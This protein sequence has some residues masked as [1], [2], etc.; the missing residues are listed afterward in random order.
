MI[1]FES[2]LYNVLRK[3][4][5]YTS[6][7]CSHRKTSDPDNPFGRIAESC[8]IN[9]EGLNPAQAKL[10]TICDNTASGMQHVRVLEDTIEH[11]EKKN[12]GHNVQTLLIVSP[13]LTAYGAT[14]ISYAAAEK[15]IRTIFVCSG[16]LLGCNEPKRYFSPVLAQEQFSAKPNLLKVNRRVLGKYE[17][18]ACSRCNWTASFSARESAFES[19]EAELSELG[20]SN[21]A[22]LA[23]GFKINPFVLKDMGI[24]PPDLIP[25]STFDEARYRGIDLQGLL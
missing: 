2:S 21:L 17:G 4:I 24:N 22:L 19:S 3:D 13:L 20:T 18:I 16:Q 23:E 8:P 10:I 14:N 7:H 9:Y 25:Y 11:I 15:G 12:G 5:P 6:A 1:R